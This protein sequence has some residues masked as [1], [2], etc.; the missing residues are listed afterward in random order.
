MENITKTV[1]DAGSVKLYYFDQLSDEAKKVA[2][3]WYKEIDDIPFLKDEMREYMI[4][5]LEK[6]GYAVEEIEP[7]Y[8]LSYCQGDGA[9]FTGSFS[10]DGITYTAKLSPGLYVHQNMMDI[11]GTD[12]EGEY[13]DSQRRCRKSVALSRR[14]QKKWDTSISKTREAMRMSTKVSVS[15]STLFQEKAYS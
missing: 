1:D 9:S 11:E 13:V 12:A 3:E 8:S 2:R 10:K 4:A 7:H 15:T 14:R 6:A 5:S